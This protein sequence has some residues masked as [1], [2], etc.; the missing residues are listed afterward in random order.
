[1]EKLVLKKEFFGGILYDKNFK[2]NIYVDKETYEILATMDKDNEYYKE[3][4]KNILKE[5]INVEEILE[6]LRELS[7]N[8]IVTLNLQRYKQEYIPENYLSSPFRVFYD[9]TYKCNLRCKHCFTNSGIKNKNE[10]LLE[11]KINLVDQLSHLGVQRISIAGGEPF[12]TE[13]IYKFIDKCNEKDIDVSISTNGTL[14]NKEIINKINCLKIKNITISFDGG[15]EK[16]MDFIRGEGTYKKVID[17]L[18]MLQENYNKNYSI[19][20]TLMK[21]NIKEIENL[22]NIAIKYNCDTIKFNC[23]RED[24]RASINKK[25]II[26]SQD[27]YIEAVKQ[28]EKLKEKYGRQVKIRAPLNI[29]CGDEDDYEFIPELGFGC[30]AGKESICIDPLGN[31]KPCSHYP[32]EFICGNIREHELKEIWNNSKILQ[33]FRKLKGNDICNN[34]K[35]YE[36]CRGGCRYRCYINGDIN[37]IDPFCYLKNNN[38]KLKAQK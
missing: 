5:N 34:C 35:E 21:N 10:L 8:E 28:I 23:V 37:G 17:G 6:I 15:T 38:K 20:V 27:E 24:G 33:N 19:K 36:H 4:I 14:F 30:F 3:N 29:F 11:E 16:S 31:V 22:I 13:D 26:L 18:K 7:E 12:I 32:K 2:E 1:M 9:I 25:D